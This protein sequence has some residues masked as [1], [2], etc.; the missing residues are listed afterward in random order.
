MVL[1]T[2]QVKQAQ[3][4]KADADAALLR[5]VRDCYKWLITPTEEFDRGKL[6]LRWEVVA[7]STNAPSL[8]VEIENKPR[9]EGLLIPEW[10][11][12]HTDVSGC[13]VVTS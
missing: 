13:L 4:L 8:V 6:T 2:I 10:S 9:E 3:K 1:D 11:P 7:V 12:I 5:M